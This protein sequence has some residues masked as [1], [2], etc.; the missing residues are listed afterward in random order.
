[1]KITA[2]IA[3][4]TL[5]ACAPGPL[6]EPAPSPKVTDPATDYRKDWFPT[7]SED[8]LPL[9]RAILD[10]NIGEVRKLLEQGA[11][12]SAR[13]K[14]SGDGF[15]LQLVLDHE[16]FGYHVSDP[17]EV[18][19]LLIKHGADPNAKWCPF[20][21]RGPYRWSCRSA[22]GLTPL[23][24]AANAG[25]TEAVAMLLEAGADAAPRN[26]NGESALDLATTEIGFE[27]ISRSLFP[28]VATRDQ[29][30]LNWLRDDTEHPIKSDA[31]LFS[32][33]MARASWLPP[34]PPPPP[35]PPFKETPA[36]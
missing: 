34:S 8:P 24:G 22:Q 31:T 5:T 7:N 21:W 20:E 18:I 15:G 35:P 9:H 17:T 2:M 26:W 23:M 16:G 10:D 3:V 25:L 6:P 4:V 28:V 30:A 29:N 14:D 36:W 32:R 27:L 13:W 11:D 19:R 33:A 1:M 12:P